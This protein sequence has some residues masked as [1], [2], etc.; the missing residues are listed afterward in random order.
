MKIFLWVVAAVSAIAGA[1]RLLSYATKKL[2][3]RLIQKEILLGITVVVTRHLK[4]L[5]L[6]EIKVL[7][8]ALNSMIDTLT[9]LWWEIYEWKPLSLGTCSLTLATFS[10]NF[11]HMSA[12]NK[13]LLRLARKLEKWAKESRDGGWSTHQVE[14]MKEEAKKIRQFVDSQPA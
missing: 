6:R 14:P 1:I 11:T 12:S 10:A 5:K 9:K 7:V 13:E 3:Y 4:E 2:E 8:A